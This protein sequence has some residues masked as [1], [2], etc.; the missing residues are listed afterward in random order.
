M[1]CF[2]IFCKGGSKLPLLVITL[3]AA[4]SGLL[5]GVL[6]DD[7]P[8]SMSKSSKS[9]SESE[10]SVSELVTYFILVDFAEFCGETT[11]FSGIDSGVDRLDCLKFAAG[12]KTFQKTHNNFSTLFD[13]V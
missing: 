11:I 5:V 10:L 1:I 2:I 6:L 13:S 9:F 3:L 12:I 8:E 4:T 7:I